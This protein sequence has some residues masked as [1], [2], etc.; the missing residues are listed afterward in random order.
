MVGGYDVGFTSLGMGLRSGSDGLFAENRGR[1]DANPREQSGRK[2][3]EGVEEWQRGPRRVI[4]TFA[5]RGL[6]PGCVGI[7]WQK[8]EQRTRAVVAPWGSLT[9]LSELGRIRELDDGLALRITAN[10]GTHSQLGGSTAPGRSPVLGRALICRPQHAVKGTED[11]GMSV[12]VSE[13][14]KTSGC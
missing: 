5:V 11:R 14:G 8:F 9:P 10:I 3:E 1:C 13:D 12:D 2:L 7:A 4:Y 6:Q